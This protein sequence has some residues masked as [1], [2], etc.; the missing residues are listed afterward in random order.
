VTGQ[1][2]Q[3]ASLLLDN[4]ELVFSEFND[5]LSTYVFQTHTHKLMTLNVNKHLAY[6][7]YVMMMNDNDTA[8]KFKAVICIPPSSKDLLL[9]TAL[10][11]IL[12]CYVNN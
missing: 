6:P 5:F 10:V 1:Q 2:Q 8:S 12:F 4:L 11:L 9:D 3:Q 7:C